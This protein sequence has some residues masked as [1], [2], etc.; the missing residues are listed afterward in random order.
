M[1][2][3]R[4]TFVRGDGRHERSYRLWVVDRNGGGARLL[5]PRVSGWA[6][7]TR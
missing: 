6:D 5:A 1:P 4:V 2:V 7:L 3:G